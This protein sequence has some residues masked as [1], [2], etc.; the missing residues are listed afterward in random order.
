MFHFKRYWSMYH[1]K[2][3]QKEFQGYG[4][5][6]NTQPWKKLLNLTQNTVLPFTSTN[7][8][9]NLPSSK[10]TDEEM[11]ILRYVLKHSIE[12]NFMSK[13]DIHSTFDF[14]HRTMSKDLKDQKD[15]EEVKAKISYLANT[16]VNSYKPTKKTLWKHKILKKLRNNN[17]ILITKPDKENGYSI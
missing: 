11:N 4:K 14:I 12:P 2:F 5:I 3:D 13:T 16:Y 7:T 9:H 17:N 1:L 10:L 6:D 8:V 15:T